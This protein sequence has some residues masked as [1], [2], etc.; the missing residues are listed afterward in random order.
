MRTLAPAALAA[1]AVA[2]IP[3]WWHIVLVDSGLNGIIAVFREVAIYP[4]DVCLA[5]LALIAVCRSRGLDSA[6]RLLAL[7]LTL[8]SI[9]ALGSAATA[10]D[11]ALASA[12][13]AQLA[14]LT[15]AW[16]GIRWLNVPRTLLVATLV[17]SAVI[18][19]TLAAAQFVTQQSLIPVQLGLPWLPSDPTRG[20]APVILDALGDRLLR[21][22]GTFP[23]P[24][25]LGGYLAIAMVC[26]P[27]LYRRWPR[28][29]P[30]VTAAGAVLVI[31]LLV[32]FSRGA[33][34]ATLVGFGVCWWRGAP[35]PRPH[36]WLPVMVGCAAL[37]GI[38]ITPLAPLVEPRVLPFG[39]NGNALER[40]S[41]QDRLA[42]DVAAVGEIAD[43]W[44]RGMG[45]GNYG[46]VSVSEGFQEGWGEPVPNVALLI[47]AELGLA[48]L[49]ALA[50]LII[51]TT[52]LILFEAAD[53][54]AVSASI[55]TLIVLGSFDHY[56]W[57]MPL[58][59]VMVWTAF[60]ILAA[61]DHVQLRD[62][63]TAHTLFS[64]A[65]PPLGPDG[66]PARVRRIPSVQQ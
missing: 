48:G 35:K 15:L 28:A 3:L 36:R 21:G 6:S 50:L 52:R 46:Q 51:A 14:L 60:A 56:L 2:L 61:R 12:L 18:Q 59:R 62:G 55:V 8:L 40:G 7:G 16:L 25:V 27:L 10:P 64:E 29:A 43:H 49:A 20:G 5:G 11:P 4:S 33:W 65:T 53:D 24:N 41:I 45:G 54:I 38:W 66:G 19:S 32:S 63:I 17:A 57:T 42:L 26:L 22:F 13:A 47:A 58:G 1:T 34:L 23:H 44:P 31:G 39:P 37:A 9:A 30:L